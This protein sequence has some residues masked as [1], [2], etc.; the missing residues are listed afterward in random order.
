MSSD[1]ETAAE[2]TRPG[3]KAE[4]DQGEG[5]RCLPSV[6][7]ASPLLSA[8]RLRERP[9]INSRRRHESKSPPFGGLGLVEFVDELAADVQA[10]R[11]RVSVIARR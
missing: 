2:A 3:E 8:P 1:A 9:Q 6:S 10:A 4:S 5:R 7:P 11:R